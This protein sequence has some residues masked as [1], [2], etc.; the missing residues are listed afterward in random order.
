MMFK[1]KKCEEGKG[2]FGFLNVEVISDRDK[3]SF[4]VILG[5]EVYFL[6]NWGVIRRWGVD[7]LC[8]CRFFRDR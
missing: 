7:I 3:S 6:I 2:Y 8:I 5:W 1:I 4:I